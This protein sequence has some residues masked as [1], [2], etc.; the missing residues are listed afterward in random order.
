VRIKYVDLRP[1]HGD[2]SNYSTSALANLIALAGTFHSMDH[3]G[4]EGFEYSKG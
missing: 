4:Q 2:A 3:P 1:P